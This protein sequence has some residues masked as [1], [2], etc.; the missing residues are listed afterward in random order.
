MLTHRLTALF[1]ALALL[2]GGMLSQ[3]VAAETVIKFDLA[4][5]STGPD[6]SYTS[7]VLS[8]TDDGDPSTDGQQSTDVKYQ[9]FLGFIPSIASG[10]SMTLSGITADGAAMGTVGLISQ[11]TSGGMFNL[12]D[13]SNMLLLS[14]NFGSGVIAGSTVS[15]GASFFSTSPVFY[16]GGSL[17]PLIKPDS[18]VISLSFTDVRTSGNPGLVVSNNT[19]LNFSGNAT[20]LLEA[21]AVPEPS[22]IGMAGI[23]ALVLIRRQRRRRKANAAPILK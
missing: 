4:D 10:A 6:I 13:D 15:T 7:G 9:G 22:V 12:F 16:T 3:E 21:S 17:L 8:T 11:E 18:G 5:I 23:G 1:A 2:A 14:G 19:L 20:G